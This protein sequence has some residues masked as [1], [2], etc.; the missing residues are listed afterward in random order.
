MFKGRVPYIAFDW[1]TLWGYEKQHPTVTVQKAYDQ[2]KTKGPICGLFMWA[3]PF[4]VVTDVELAR[5][6]LIKE[7]SSFEDRGIYHN[8]KD[9]PVGQ[10]L[11]ASEGDYWRTKRK[12]MTTSFSSGKIKAML[13]VVLE[14]CEELNDVLVAESSKDINWDL[15]NVLCRFTAD[16]IGNVAFGLECDQLKNSNNSKFVDVGMEAFR[17]LRPLTIRALLSF[18]FSKV[19]RFFKIKRL[20]DNINKFYSTIVRK[21]ISF[22]E[23]N[24]IVKE[25]LIGSM[26]NMM[27]SNLFNVDE[28]ISSSFSFFVAGFETTANTLNYAF[29][30]L[31]LYPELQEQIRGEVL[32]VLDDHNQQLTYEAV[33]DMPLVEKALLGNPCNRQIWKF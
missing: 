24:S 27:K 9:D 8:P 17:E 10:D 32:S 18:E 23:E 28:V 30:N 13:P 14:K 6:V 21:T 11:F 7:F 16:V 2:L 15:K 1:K 19:A 4:L 31:A 12:S 33:S 25:D 3:N 22:R 20:N 29:Y 5:T 26:I